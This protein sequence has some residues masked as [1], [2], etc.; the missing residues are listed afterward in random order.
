LHC[1]LHTG[2][3]LWSLHATDLQ[4][5]LS[6]LFSR[7]SAATTQLEP[8]SVLGPLHA[9]TRNNNITHTHTHTKGQLMVIRDSS[10]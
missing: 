3:L 8:D 4:L 2:A 7:D 6:S 5:F 9:A 10:P 1:I